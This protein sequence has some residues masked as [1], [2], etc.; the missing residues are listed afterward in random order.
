MNEETA[1]RDLDLEGLQDFS[2]LKDRGLSPFFAGRQD[3]LADL[4]R[5]CRKTFEDW[6]AGGD[7][8]G[9]TVVVTGCQGMGKTALLRRFE[10]ECNRAAD[11]ASPLAFRM[12]ADE[13][14]NAGAAAEALVEATA[15]DGKIRGV[16]D[17]LGEDIARD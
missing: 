4:T 8:S 16:L 2:R 6:R 1:A 17:A 15:E 10:S 11:P 9:S 5:R 3:E 7:I 13:L 12:P 14:R